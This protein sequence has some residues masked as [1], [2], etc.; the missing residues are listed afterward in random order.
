MSNAMSLPTSFIFQSTLPVWGAT[1][2]DDPVYCADLISI[3]APRVGSDITYRLIPRLHRSFQSTL[4]VWGATNSSRTFIFSPSVISIHA[5]RVGS[6]DFLGHKAPFAGRFQSTL[7]VWGATSIAVTGS[8]C[9][10]I[11]I[12]APRVGSDP[13]RLLHKLYVRL[14]QSTLPVWGATRTA[15]CSVLFRSHFNP[16]SPCGERL[17]TQIVHNNQW[18]F[19]STLPV[20]GATTLASVFQ[21]DKAISIHAPRVGSDP[22]LDMVRAGWP[23]FNPRS[24]CGERPL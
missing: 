6:D 24:P 1:P 15:R 10:P 17:G 4:P 11:S 21:L 18:E 5:P 2:D 13:R 14:F 20:W 23:D 19:Q 3:H 9:S 22:I 7:P 16:R 12:H 8:G